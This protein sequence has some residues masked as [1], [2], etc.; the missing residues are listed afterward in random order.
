MLKTAVVVHVEACFKEEARNDKL[1]R[2]IEQKLKYKAAL[3]G[4]GAGRKVKRTRRLEV[5]G[6]KA[7]R[8]S[9]ASPRTPIAD[10][11]PARALDRC[12]VYLS[13]RYLPA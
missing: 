9:R 2:E 13:G 11:A 8:V 5:G 3:E 6:S 4:T 7:L 10:E 1:K 12:F